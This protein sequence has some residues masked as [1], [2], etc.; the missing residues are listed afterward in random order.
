MQICLDNFYDWMPKPH[1]KN[2][3]SNSTSRD[4]HPKLKCKSFVKGEKEDFQKL[5][6]RGG[7][8]KS[9]KWKGMSKKVGSS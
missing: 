4:L 6:I 3:Y 5:G 9:I 8:Q 7:M 1:Y 2:H